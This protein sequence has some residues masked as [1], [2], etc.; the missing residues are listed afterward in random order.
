MSHWLPLADALLVM[1]GEQ[2]LFLVI[3]SSDF[4]LIFFSGSVM[5][6]WLPLADALLGMIVEQIPSP[7][8]AQADRM[9]RLLPLAPPPPHLREEVGV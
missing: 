1:I 7:V 4:F 9:K 5:S 3:F 2:I 6:R 8:C